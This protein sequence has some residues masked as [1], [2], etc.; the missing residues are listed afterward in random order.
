MTKWRMRF[1]CRITNATDTHEDDLI[2]IAFARQQWL[3]ERSIILRYKSIAYR[4]F[5]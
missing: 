2:L 5:C 4:V 1:V 3:S